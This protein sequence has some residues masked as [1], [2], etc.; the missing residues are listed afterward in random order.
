MHGGIGGG[1]TMRILSNGDGMTMSGLWKISE[2]KGIY[3][4]KNN[5][6]YLI[7]HVMDLKPNSTMLIQHYFLDMKKIIFV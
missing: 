5:I 3:I 7:R 6:I 2:T 4:K 1:R